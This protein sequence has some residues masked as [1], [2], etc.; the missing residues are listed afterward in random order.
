MA[1]RNTGE[2]AVFNYRVNE[3]VKIIARGG[4]RSEFLQLA[5][6]Q[7]WGVSDRTCDTYLKVA[8]EKL[9]QDWTI[10][11]QQMVADLLTQLSTLQDEARKAGNLAVALGCINS[12]GRIAQIVSGS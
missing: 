8:R 5:A 11:R 12:A 9:Q 6:D 1:R 2:I 3:C 7:G 10:D 4:R